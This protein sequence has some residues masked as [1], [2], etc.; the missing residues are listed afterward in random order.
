M[1]RNSA[2]RQNDL[3]K[4]WN[5]LAKKGVKAANEV[6]RSREIKADKHSITVPGDI[7]QRLRLLAFEQRLS[8]SSIVEIALRGLFDRGDDAFLGR[9]LREN[10]AT[11]RRKFG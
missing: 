9:I 5:G 7:G 11:L 8:E 4:K 2:V 10:G 6:V 3:K 1:A